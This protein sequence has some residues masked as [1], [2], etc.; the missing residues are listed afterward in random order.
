M[1]SKIGWLDGVRFPNVLRTDRRFWKGTPSG[2]PLA[3]RIC[4]TALRIPVTVIENCDKSRGKGC[5]PTA[6]KFDKRKEKCS[7]A[8]RE[9]LTVKIDYISIIFDSA[10]AEDVIRHVLELPPDIFITYPKKV[11]FK[12]YQTCWQIGDIYLSGNAEKTEDNPQG[13][14]CYLVM[15]G[16]GCDD[17]FRI[18]DNR[19][20]TFGELFRQCERWFGTE[21]HFTRLDIAIDDR[22]EV[23]FFT[24]QQLKKKC[25]KEEYISS[26]EYCRNNESKYPHE[27]WAGTLYIGAG[28]SDI[29]FRIYDKDREVSTKYNRTLEEIG[30]WKRT[31]IQL[32]DKKA[33]AFAMLLKDNPLDLGQLAFN[34]LSS[35]LRFVVPNMN[36]SN[37][38]RWKTCR[39]W[40]RFLGSVEPLKLHIPQIHNTLM[41]TQQWLKEGGVLSAVKG[42]YYLEQNDALG[43]LERVDAM[44]E[45]VRYSPSFAG[46]LTA[47]LQRIGREE[48][49]PFIL[50]DTRR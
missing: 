7:I 4:N 46:K 8:K 26:S 42:F 24:P 35:N 3:G 11:A 43:D 37:R 25:E 39:F 2:V 32:R 5:F 30:S 28:K 23:P 13:T 16:R 31:E 49:I 44:L 48:L 10:K 12:T 50:Y 45:T 19:G 15:T 1:V 40:E 18:L 9:N 20:H 14:G 38:S 6:Q 17:I 47:H 36:E 21:F 34:L 27:E 29:S 33:H 41:E 22:N